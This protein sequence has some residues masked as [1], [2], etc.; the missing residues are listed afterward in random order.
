MRR[1]ELNILHADGSKYWSEGFDSRLELN[2]WLNAEKTRTYW[3][4]DFKIEIVDN[5]AAVDQVEKDQKDRADKAIADR[6]V[7]TDR[8][9]EFK[10]KP[11]KTPKDVA[12]AV[13]DLL[14]LFHI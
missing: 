12:D 5:S 6:K 10:A 9:A 8:L 1:F 4:K 13:V 7:I 14:E 2:K 3:K 11:S